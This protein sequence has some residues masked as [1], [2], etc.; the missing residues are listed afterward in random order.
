MLPD[1]NKRFGGLWDFRLLL[2]IDI[3][4]HQL[5]TV[6]DKFPEDVAHESIGADIHDYPL[7]IG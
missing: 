4:L 5:L 1:R 3:P 6:S 2:L 7:A